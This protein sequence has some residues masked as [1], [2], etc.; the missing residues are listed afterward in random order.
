M[1]SFNRKV[2]LGMGTVSVVL[3]CLAGTAAWLIAR[4]NAEDTFVTLAVEDSRRLLQHEAFRPQGPQATIHAQA[5]AQALVGG[6]FDIASIYTVDGMLMAEQMTMAGSALEKD[7]MPHAPPAY[8]QA[9]YESQQL[10][11]NRWVLRMFVPLRSAEQAITGYLEGV[12]L[13]PQWQRELISSDALKVALMVALATLLCG[14]ALYPMVIRLFANSQHKTHEVLES[15]LS[16]MQALGR[17]IARRDSDTGIHNYRVAW[18]AA[19]LAEAVGLHGSRMQELIVGSFLHDVGKIGIPDAILLKPG[20]LSDDEMAVMHTHVGMGEEIVTG[21]GWVDGGRAVV[22][23]HHEKWDGTGYP[24]GLAG[25]D[26]ALVARIFAIADV[27]DALCSQRPHKQP[28]PLDEVMQ[29]LN[30]GAGKHFDPHLVKVFS[31]LAGDVYQA[32]AN[33]T[34]LEVKTRLEL[35]VHKHFGL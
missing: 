24:R 25:E 16:M 29:V 32:L 26:I 7:L 28:M 4:E 33:A 31:G 20:R 17:A 21:A 5:A 1:N 35:M 13:V 22:A 11:G 6:L 19:T 8:P 27:F 12:R 9:F 34:E 30:D 23:G 3:A 2:A 15:H 18:I 14:G 10:P